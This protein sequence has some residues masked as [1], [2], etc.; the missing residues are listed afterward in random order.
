MPSKHDRFKYM[1]ISWIE[2]NLLFGTRLGEFRNYI[3]LKR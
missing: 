1:I 3:L 2:K